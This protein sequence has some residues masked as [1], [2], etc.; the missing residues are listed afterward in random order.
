[1]RSTRQGHQVPAAHGGKLIAPVRSWS[2]GNDAI[3]ADSAKLTLASKLNAL[4]NESGLSQYEAARLLSMTQ[5]KVSAIKNYKLRGISLER[6]M[7]ALLAMGQHVEIV[8]TP[9][10]QARGHVTLPR[11]HVHQ[12]MQPTGRSPMS[13]GRGSR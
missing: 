5:P 3:D 7:Q 8:V 4:L 13:Q 6:L 11:F 2:A 9:S 1:M 12:V 10:R